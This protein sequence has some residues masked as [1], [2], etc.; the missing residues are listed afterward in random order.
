VVQDAGARDYIAMYAG[1]LGDNA[2]ERYAAFLAALGP[3]PVQERLA[4]LQRARAH[5]LDVA[6]VA[7][8]AAERTLDICLIVCPPASHSRRTMADSTLLCQ[9]LPPLDGPLP[10]I[11]LRVDVDEDGSGEER[12]ERLLLRSLEWTTFSPSTFALA[13][14]HAALVLRYFLG[15]NLLH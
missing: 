12:M 7:M 15:A 10:S 2:V 6:R 4:A 3:A 5:G 1:A 9:A 14:E 13:L 8:A 11:E